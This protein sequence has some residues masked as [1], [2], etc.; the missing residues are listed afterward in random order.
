MRELA[1]L[2]NRPGALALGIGCLN[3]LIWA[4]YYALVKHAG[5]V[6]VALAF[7][8][9]IPTVGF[10]AWIIIVQAQAAGARREALRA[11]GTPMEAVGPMAVTARLAV[12]CLGPTLALVA[13]LIAGIGL[14]TSGAYH[15]WSHP[16]Q[17]AV[18]LLVPAA[19]LLVGMVSTQIPAVG[20]R[21]A[22]VAIIASL[23]AGVLA[24]LLG[25]AGYLMYPWFV[26]TTG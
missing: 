7:L 21:A 3:G 24:A 19:T 1:K 11:A 9:G 5:L 14:M 6:E 10:V 12:G 23:G 22:L 18:L 2:R 8:G 25:V 26:N 13:G 15:E 4:A 20:R 16:D 17:I